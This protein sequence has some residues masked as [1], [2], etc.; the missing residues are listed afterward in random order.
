MKNVSIHEFEHVLIELITERFTD[1]VV[2]ILHGG[3]YVKD[4]VF[5]LSKDGKRLEFSPYELYIKSKDYEE[6]IESFL[7]EWEEVL[8]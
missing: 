5:E 3:D 2:R 6:T 4:F 1:T 7:A 8:R